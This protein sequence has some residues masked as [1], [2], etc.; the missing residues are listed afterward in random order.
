MLSGELVTPTRSAR[1]WFTSRDGG[2]SA[3]PF[4][5]RNLA[6]HVGDDLVAVRSNREELEQEIGFGPLSWMGPVHGVGIETVD[7]V[8]ALAPNVDAL[9]TRRSGRPLVTL[10]ADCVPLVMIAGDLAI[11]AHVGWRGFVAGMTPS[12]L[13]LL[14]EQDID[15]T[16]AQVL[17]GP[18]ICGVCYGIPEDRANAIRTVCE[19]AVVTAHNGGPGADIRIGLTAQWAAVGA[20]VQSV[21][22]CTFEDHRYFSHRRDGVAG[23]QAGVIAWT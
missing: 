3:A 14:A 12:I 19:S 6:A 8:V 23:R 21:G 17:L 1:W 4:A 15:P 5:T 20:R 9:S 10:G 18:A 13:R 22:P 2:S 11:A 7:D 16:T